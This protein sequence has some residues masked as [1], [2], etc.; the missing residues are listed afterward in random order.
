M[1]KTHWLITLAILLLLTM[2]IASNIGALSLTW[3]DLWHTN[4]DDSQWQIWLNI[5]VPRILLAVVVGLA[6]AVSG[7]IFQGLFHNPMADPALIGV[8]SGAALAVGISIMLP[9]LLPSNLGLY[10]T[11]IAAFIGSVIV[12]SLIYFLSYRSQA[13]VTKLLLAG[14]AVNALCFSIVGILTY[15]SNDQ[16]L[17]QFSLWS[18]GSLGQAQWEPVII[19]S[20]VI[21]LTACYAL[22]LANKLNL[23][24]LGDEEAHYLGVNVIRLKKQLILLGALLVGASVA[25]SGA[26]GFIG[27]VIP[28]LVR[29]KFGA[30]HRWVLPASALCGAILLLVADTLARTMVSPAELPVGMLTSFIGAPYFLW[31]VI[32]YREGTK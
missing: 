5:R 15:I 32:R 4:I 6:L 20:C 12:S 30:D 7:T 1:D 9:S 10:S 29:F 3:H 31:L 22:T 21:L 24:Q 25:V 27:L 16:Q 28:H 17:R 19:A 26:I 18:M 11:M 13:S 8:N 2:L 14:I 23:L